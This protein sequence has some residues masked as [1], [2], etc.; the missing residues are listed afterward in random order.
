MKDVS[1]CV[2]FEMEL[3]RSSKN[4]HRVLMC[5]RVNEEGAT[6]ENPDSK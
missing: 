6:R 3:L 5:V 4:T 2:A 1:A